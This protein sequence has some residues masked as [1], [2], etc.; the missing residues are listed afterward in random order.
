MAKDKFPSILIVLAMALLS[1]CHA[2]VSRPTPDAS[3]STAPGHVEGK[4][5]PLSASPGVGGDKLRT[6][7]ASSDIV[8][9]D[10]V[11]VR[12]YG[13][14]FTTNGVNRKV[15]VE[16]GWDYRRGV[17]VETVY[18]ENGERLSRIDKP[19]YTLNFSNEELELAIALAREE[20]SLHERLSASDL[21]FY[22]GF[23]YR[24]AKE[25]DCSAGSRC[26]HVIVSAGDGQRH[27]AHA[28]VDL[29]SRRV[30]HASLDPDR[31][32]D[33]IPDHS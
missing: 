21:N 15:I 5:P 27:V 32:P 25:P 3:K 2:D 22:A 30:I 8:L 33:P 4:L 28:I 26:V 31:K 1:A 20:T 7:L 10:Y 24:E 13:D 18:D 29:M 19:G 14:V 12:R 11:P 9:A 23:A 17:V 6:D 16:Y